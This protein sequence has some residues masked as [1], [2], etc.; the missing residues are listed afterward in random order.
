M[1]Q[2]E[3]DYPCV[4]GPLD[5]LRV[6]ASR[7]AWCPAGVVRFAVVDRDYAVPG[8]GKRPVTGRVLD[9]SAHDPD[10]TGAV[11][12]TYRLRGGRLVYDAGG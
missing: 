3:A 1:G 11:P 2:P 9:R 4:G 8:L 5:G 10:M 7:V 6:P 12:A